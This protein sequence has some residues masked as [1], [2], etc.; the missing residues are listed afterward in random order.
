MTKNTSSWSVRARIQSD[1]WGNRSIETTVATILNGRQ[2]KCTLNGLSRAAAKRQQPTK[3]FVDFLF[4]QMWHF[5]SSP[6]TQQ[7]SHSRRS[8]DEV[9]LTCGEYRWNHTTMQ[10]AITSWLWSWRIVVNILFFKDFSL[11]VWFRHRMR[12]IECV[13][14]WLTPSH[15]VLKIYKNA[16]SCVFT[17]RRCIFHFSFVKLT[18]HQMKNIEIDGQ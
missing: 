17:R 8:H 11:F 7:R 18:K 13:A 9:H 1:T 10:C 6:E 15:F 4:S 2:L 3:W 5:S 14:H 16:M 12:L